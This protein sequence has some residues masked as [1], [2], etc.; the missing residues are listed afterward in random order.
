MINKTSTCLVL[1]VVSPLFSLIFWLVSPT[2]L[3]NWYW[4]AILTSSDFKVRESHLSILSI[5]L[6]V[7][8]EIDIKFCSVIAE[9]YLPAGAQQSNNR[10]SRF[11]ESYEKMTETSH[12][13][14]SPNTKYGFFHNRMH[15]YGLAT[16][17][18]ICITL[19]PVIVILG[20]SQPSHSPKL[21]FK[22]TL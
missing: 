7:L 20:L 12:T 15:N 5:Y 1:V 14:V 19:L 16:H 11:R 21:S 13:P 17:S 3:L 8:F 6:S 9:I 22:F 18:Q 4:Y 10:K 2:V